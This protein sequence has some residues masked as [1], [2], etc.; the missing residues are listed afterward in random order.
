MCKLWCKNIEDNSSPFIKKVRIIL[1]VMIIV[2]IGLLA[3]Q[4]I[5]VPK[6]VAYIIK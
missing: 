6:L 4:N 5:W 3:T 1:L 2:G